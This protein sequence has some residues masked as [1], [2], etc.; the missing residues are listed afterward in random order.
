MPELGVPVPLVSAPLT[1]IF[2]LAYH[3]RAARRCLHGMSSLSLSLSRRN[4][5]FADN[6]VSRPRF[7][8]S[9][10]KHEASGETDGHF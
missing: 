7:V 5:I 2:I 6:A 9:S 8:A 3:P 4:L 10:T 1:F